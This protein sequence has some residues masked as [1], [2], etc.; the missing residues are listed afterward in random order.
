MRSHSFGNKFCAA[1]DDQI[2][3]VP[4][5]HVVSTRGDRRPLAPDRFKVGLIPIAAAVLPTSPPSPTGRC[6]PSLCLAPPP[7]F[8]TSSSHPPFPPHTHH[9]HGAPRLP[10]RAP[11]AGCPPAPASSC[12]VWHGRPASGRPA[13][14]AVPAGVGSRRH[15]RGGGRAPTPPGGGRPPDGR[16]PPRFGGGHGGSVSVSVGRGPASGAWRCATVTSATNAT[17]GWHRASRRWG[18][19][20]PLFLTR[21]RT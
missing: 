8:P 4:P 6:P 9:H 1:V 7:R 2:S 21:H 20:S 14:E 13:S 17:V 16:A 10:E 19:G 12:G 3:L 11:A 18:S 15:C 5:R